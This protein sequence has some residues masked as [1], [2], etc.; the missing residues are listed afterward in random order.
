V[1]L[2]PSAPGTAV[3]ITQYGDQQDFYVDYG[4]DSYVDLYVHPTAMPVFEQQVVSSTAKYVQPSVSS[5]VQSR[6][7][8]GTPSPSP[9]DRVFFSP[10][11][12]L[13]YF[14]YAAKAVYQWTSLSSLNAS[15]PFISFG[16]LSG[17]DFSYNSFTGKNVQPYAVS[18]D[19]SY[20]GWFYAVGL[21]V[22]ASKF[23]YYTIDTTGG[24]PVAYE[25][26]DITADLTGATNVVP[27]GVATDDTGDVFVAY[28]TY[29]GSTTVNSSIIDYYYDS[30][31]QYY[32]QGAASTAAIFTDV[33][34]D[35]GQLW[36]LASPVTSS[37]LGGSSFA[38]TGIADI[39]TTD[40]SLY[41]STAN[42][43]S[44]TQV[45]IGSLPTLP[46]GKLVIPNRFA[47]P[48]QGNLLYLSQ[49]DFFAGTGTDNLTSVDL[50]TGAVVDY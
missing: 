29:D 48:I 16:S 35:Q 44:V 45:Y 6:A 18:A 4:Y 42:Q 17:Y 28:Y 36:V 19:P 5:T 49:F 33:T 14:N 10:D 23:F 32:P 31:Y 37:A 27:T 21:D 25:G 38:N 22:S 46:A 41:Q 1:A 43:F 7:V 24:S 13:F 47:G 12:G 15:T 34:F 39:L 40:T 9:K 50:T 2:T 11:G 30:L 20:P 8:V 26:P 3:G